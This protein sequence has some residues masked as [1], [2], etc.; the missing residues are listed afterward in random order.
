[1]G[2]GE[3]H[4]RLAQRPRR[5]DDAFL[6]QRHFLGR[7][8]H[9][10]VAAR[11]HHR[12]GQAQDGVEV[13]QRLR[14]LQLGHDPGAATGDVARLLDILRALH[15]RQADVV[16]AVLQRERQI[17]AVLLGQRRDRQHHVRHVDPLAVRQ[18][19]ADGDFGFQMVLAHMRH[20]QPQ[21][22][23]VEQQRSADRG[24]G[25]DLRMR[26]VHP[27][28]VARRGIEVEP[29]RMPGLQLHPPAGEAADSQLGALYVGQD[30]NGMRDLPLQVADDGEQLGVVVMGAV[31]EIEPEHVGPGLQQAQ[32]HLG[33][34]AGR[35]ERR[36][37]FG[38]AAAAQLALLDHGAG[39]RDLVRNLSRWRRIASHVRLWNRRDTHAICNRT[40]REASM[41]I[42]DIDPATTT[43]LEA[44]AFRR[45]VAHL[46]ERGDVA[47]IDLMNLAGFCRNCLS[48]WY[49][50]AAEAQG[51]A[52]ADSDAREIVYGMPYKQWQADHQ[53]P[54][55][56]A[57]QAAFAKSRQDL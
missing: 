52:L 35:A 5:A 47:N 24:G 17:L 1:V 39:S 50:E 57:Q 56:A 45:L 49:R 54:A 13:V 42:P 25:D 21:L 32:Q 15:E 7:Q 23:V 55:T 11:H 2:E 36:D 46:R 16:G 29:E 8:L 28:H 19:A 6:G 44:A 22:A 10:E 38:A 34:G 26:Q 12:V 53:A 37:D 14:L 43:E 4:H 31:A 33:R 9:A 30:A 41:S 48:R 3:D 20:P 40:Q 51:V 27:A 18:R